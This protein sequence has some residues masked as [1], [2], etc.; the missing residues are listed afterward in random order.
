[1]EKIKADIANAEAI[2]LDVRTEE[3]WTEEH[4]Q[5]ALHIPLDRITS[6]YKSLL[7]TKS[8]VYIYCG[9]GRRASEARSILETVGLKAVNIGGLKDWKDAG[10]ETVIASNN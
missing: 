9:S 10:G 7:N 2:L 8:P 5:G 3:E 4:A 1:M 6:E